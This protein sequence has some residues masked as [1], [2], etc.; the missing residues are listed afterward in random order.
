MADGFEVWDANWGVLRAF[1]ACETQW[2]A[3]A[4]FGG[5]EWIGIDYAA[6]DVVLRRAGL[7]DEAFEELRLM[8]REALKA[9]DELRDA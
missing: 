2:R 1:L 5:V 4:G 6:A 3:V 7:D 9:F 8:E